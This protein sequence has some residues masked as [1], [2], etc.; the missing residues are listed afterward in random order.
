MVSG[1]RSLQH[2]LMYVSAR[3]PNAIAPCHRNIRSLPEALSCFVH[4]NLAV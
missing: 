4:V 1:T 2:V 3:Q